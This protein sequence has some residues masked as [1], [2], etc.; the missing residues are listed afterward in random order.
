MAENKSI[1]AVINEEV[2]TQL[3]D[4]KV[5]N[6]LLATTFKNLSAIS[7]KQ[8]IIEGMIRGF[9]FKDFLEKNVYAIPFRD[10]YSLITSIDYVRKLGMR[11]GLVGKSEPKFVE[12]ND[13]IISCSITIKR[14]VKDTV[15]EYTSTVYFS[16]YSTGKNLWISKP[17]T[18]LAKVA[19]MQALRSAFPEEMSQSYIEE[20]MEKEITTVTPVIDISE[21]ETKLRATKNNEEL[22]ALWPSIPAKAKV[23]LKNLKDELKA[24]HDNAKI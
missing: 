12:A 17:H 11:S 4:P 3:A 6:A 13:K 15:G 24:K 5:M 7:A 2:N 14:Q 21:Y 1:V 20:E 22:K 23:E 18:M 19:E 10:G 9:T 16:E 8:A